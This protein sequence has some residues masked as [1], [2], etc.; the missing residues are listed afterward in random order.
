M[1]EL[2][3]EELNMEELNMEELDMEELNMEELNMEELN[4]EELIWWWGGS[5]GLFFVICWI[6]WRYSG[7][8]SSGLSRKSHGRTIGEP[9]TASDGEIDE[10]SLGTLWRPCRTRW[11]WWKQS[12]L[13]SWAW[14]K[15]LSWWWNLSTIP[16][17]WGWK[18]VV[19]EWVIPRNLQSA[20]HTELVNWAP[21]SEIITN[22][23]LNRGI[24]EHRKTLAQSFA[25]VKWTHWTEE[26]DQPH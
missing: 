22:G 9:N 18:E 8:G 6:H 11:R 4:M 13:A 20:D 25:V 23:T 14:R 12:D 21:R 3:M 15:T 24:H 2:N 1:E 5:T 7:E 10:S 17:D 19:G 26:E 16:S